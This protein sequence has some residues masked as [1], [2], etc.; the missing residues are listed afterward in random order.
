MAPCQPLQEG[1]EL[2]G[3]QPYDGSCDPAV[4][5]G[6]AQAS[7]A[8]PAVRVAPPPEMSSSSGSGR[9]ATEVRALKIHSEA[10]RRRRERIN[11]HL[12]TLRRMVPD[13]RQMDKATLLARVVEQVKH[14]KR[15]ASEATQSMPLPPETNEVSIELHTGDTDTDTAA[16]GTDK[17]V[18]IKASISCDDRPDLI[19][20]LIQAFH[21]LRLRTVRADLTSLGG[22]VQHVFM[23]CNEEEGW[24]S[25]GASLRSLKEA[26]RQAMARVAAPQMAYGG[27]S[28]F[29]SKRQ[30][31]LESHYSIMSI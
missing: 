22:R 10:E 13:T 11:A 30:R 5:G 24:G 29:Q 15:R 18:Y 6:P 26:V 21:G 17:T 16:T 25:A 7:S 23:L 28:P 3:L 19:A 27:T 1:N 9:S 14:L 2:Q 20:R 4:F 12:A 31:I 8:P